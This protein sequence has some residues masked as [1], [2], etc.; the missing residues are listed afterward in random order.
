MTTESKSTPSSPSISPELQML[1]L[2]A[3]HLTAQAIHVFVTLGIPDILRD[4]PKPSAELAVLTNTDPSVLYR[5]LRFLGTVDVV[6]E[7]S[8]G[9]FH[10]TRFGKTLCSRPT[11][12]IHDNT[13]L[14]ASRYYWAAIGNMLHTVK[15]GQNAFQQAYGQGYFDRLGDHPEDAAIFNAAMNS[16]SQLGIAAILAA[17]D[18]SNFKDV[19]D[20]AGGKGA[21]IT[22]VLKKHL[23]TRGIL[24]DSAPALDQL[25][26][27]RSVAGRLTKARGSF[28]DTVPSGADAY[29][30]R[31]I[32]HDWDDENAIKI[33]RVCRNA[34]R[35]DSKL[36]LIE[37][38]AGSAKPNHD[39]ATMDL[40]MMLVLSGKERT[41]AEFESILS[42][43]GLSV[44]RIIPT[45]SPYWIVEA[46]P[47]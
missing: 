38:A 13:L 30:M 27:D 33:L 3:S 5:V 46:T 20:V 24:F 7:E 22:G 2:T 4:N 47:I 43:A 26:F 25:E 35:S 34:M 18:F 28:F 31:R 9:R 16:S 32:L 11:S 42:A 36:L 44:A 6:S 19:V 21:L 14:V 41:A 10:L 23:S 37:L 8:D 12:V 40:L 15:T 45:H 39:W 17:Y 1:R 29:L